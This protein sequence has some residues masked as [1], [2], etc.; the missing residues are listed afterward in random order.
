MAKHFT[1][2]Q[3]RL[4]IVLKQDHKT[5]SSGL[6]DFISVDSTPHAMYD[7][8][9]DLPALHLR[10]PVRTGL[11]LRRRDRAHLHRREAGQAR[12]DVPGRQRPLRQR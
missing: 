1:N 2:E 8:V 6:Q 7:K 3:D 9:R 10:L 12:E 4:K 11:H 5:F